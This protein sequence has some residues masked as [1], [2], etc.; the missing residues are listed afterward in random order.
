[1]AQRFQGIRGNEV[2]QYDDTVA[3]KRSVQ[4]WVDGHVFTLIAEISHLINE[5]PAGL[6][7][8]VPEF[9]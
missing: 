1:L 7:R 8:R 2:A 9:L 5:E 6:R 3:L 4:L